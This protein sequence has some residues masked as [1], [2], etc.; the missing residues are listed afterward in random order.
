M[1]GVRNFTAGCC[2][3]SKAIVDENFDKNIFAPHTW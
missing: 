2:I 1:V 3:I